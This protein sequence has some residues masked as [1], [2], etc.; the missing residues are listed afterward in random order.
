MTQPI[1]CTHEADR[2]IL[3]I[4]GTQH[5]YSNDKEGKRQAILDG[6]NAVETMTVG[7]DVYLPSNESL[8]V[9][10][11]VLYPDGIQTEAAYQTVCQVTEK[12][13]AH[14]GY[15]GEVELEPPVVPFARRGAYRRRYP[16]V[17]AHLVCDELALA[18]IGSSFP[19]Q[20][21][22][23]TILW[24]KAG[25]AVYGRHWSKL[26]AAEQSLIQTQ[27]DAIATQDGWEKDDIKS[28]GCYTKPLPVDE[29]TA[30]SRLDDLLRREN[31]R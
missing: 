20:E 18:G 13:C 12:A 21:I 23:C 11:A 31:G 30:R 6:L 9:V 19:R 5:T 7:E 8:Q 15:G 28:T 3:S 22:A 27:V 10:A 4:H 24:N 17:D 26:T 2:L 29:A 1:T 25:L 16:P 14:L